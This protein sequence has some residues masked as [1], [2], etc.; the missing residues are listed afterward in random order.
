MISKAP[1]NWQINE[2]MSEGRRSRLLKLAIVQ[3]G[4]S[5]K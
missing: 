1:A 4:Q 5:V 3:G 2:T